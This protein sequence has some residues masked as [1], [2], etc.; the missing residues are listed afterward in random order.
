MCEDVS[1]DRYRGIEIKDK[2]PAPNPQAPSF[3]MLCMKTLPLLLEKKLVNNYGCKILHKKKKN[4]VASGAARKKKLREKLWKSLPG[5][6]CFS[7]GFCR[8]SRSSR[9]KGEDIENGITSEI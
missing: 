5:K 1:V 9:I 4:I 8:S 6:L 2:S 7:S 3:F